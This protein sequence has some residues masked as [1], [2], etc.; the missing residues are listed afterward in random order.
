VAGRLSF[1]R[2]VV[3]ADGQAAKAGQSLDAGQVLATGPDSVALVKLPDSSIVKLNPDS[4]IRLDR[5]LAGA[6]ELTI[7][8]GAVFSE[9][10]KQKAG[11]RFMIRAKG[12][13]M[14]VRGT[15]FFASLGKSRKQGDDVWMCVNEGT[16]E[17]SGPGDSKPALV[18]EGEG[19]LV[20]GGKGATP[21]RKYEWT[22]ALNWNM[23]P[24]KGEVL[25]R[26]KIDYAD[27]LEQSYD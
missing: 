18:H 23:Q 5:V 17:I 7:E 9:V 14:G 25:D 19:V 21:P 16:V 1:S 8:A 20:P 11:R 26:T 3:T 24:E 15:R 13:T 12:V 27:L 6:T 22:K 4:R 2:G 10:S